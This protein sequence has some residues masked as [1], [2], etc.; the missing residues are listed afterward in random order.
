MS[1]E[2]NSGEE[3]DEAL[4][5]LICEYLHALEAGRQPDRAE[6][7]AAHPGLADDLAEF[8]A[9]HDQFGGIA[10]PLRQATRTTATGGPPYGAPN[11]TNGK[12]VLA[13]PPS[14]PDHA[15]HLAGVVEELGRLGDFQMVREVGRGGMG[16]V[17]EAVQISLKR[18]VALKVLP[19]AGALDP[20]QLQRFK[21]E[22]QAAAHLTHQHIVPVYFVGCERG[23]HFYAMQ[24]IDGQT[25]AQVIAE[26]RQL[27]APG[28]DNRLP[29]NGPT[30]AAEAVAPGRNPSPA[31]ADEERTSPYRP[32]LLP[33][34]SAAQETVPQAA[35][36]TEGSHRTAAYF[37]TVARLGEQAAE[38]LHHAHEMGVVHRDVK[39]G[40]LLLDGRANVWVTDFGLARMQT[41]ASLTLS[42]DLVGTLRY[43]SPEQ[44]LANRVAIDH[45]T[46]VYSLGATLYELLVLRPTFA[47]RERQELLRQIAFD[48]PAPLRRLNKAIP[49]ELETVVLKALEK[50]P[51]DRYATAKELAADLRR[52]LEDRPI[53][54]HRP[55]LA[56]RMRK[57]GRR[58]RLVVTAAAICLLVTLAAVVGSVGWVLGERA[59][60][61]RGA[62][63]KVRE[64]LDA[65]APGLRHGNPYDPGLIAAVQR[66]EAQL[67]TG[68]VG[69]GLGALVEQLRRDREMLVQLE[70]AHSQGLAGNKET[71]FNYAGQDQL[72]MQAFEGH[73][74]K[75]TTLDPQEAARRLRT[76]AIRTH[77]IAALEEWAQAKS[78]LRRRRGE[79]LIALADLADDDPWRRRLRRV[80]R[81]AD[82]IE[83]QRLARENAVLSQPAAN[84]TLLA[85]AL[86]NAGAWAVAE[87]V[88]RLAQ[89]AHPSEL[90]LNLDLAAMLRQK[91]RPDPA[92]AIRFQQAALALRPDK[93][94]LYMDLGI[95][96]HTEGKLTEAVAAHRKATELNSDYAAA[97]YNLGTALADQGKFA[98]A[99]GAFRKAVKLKPD[100]ALVHANLG[101]AL[102][103]Q[104]RL[105][106][107]VAAYRK[108]ISLK[109][110]D[111]ISHNNLGAALHQ[112]GNLIEA[113]AEY[114]KA[115]ALKPN[116]CDAYSN[117]GKALR[118]QHNLENAVLAFRKAI[119]LKPNLP[120]LHHELGNLLHS[121]HKLVEAEAAFGMAIRLKANYYD[122]Y[123]HLGMVLAEQGKVDLAE[124]AFR[125]AICLKPD[126]VSAHFN[127]GNE[128]SS[129]GKVREAIAEYKQAVRLK[130]SF[131][132][133]YSNLGNAFVRNGQLNEAITAFQQ[134]SRLKD[135][136]RIHWNLG[137]ALWKKDRL[138]EAAAQFRDVIR[139]NKDHA[140]AHCYLGVAL[141]RMG[142]PDEAIAELRKAIRLK[143]DFAEP[144]YIL[145]NALSH[146]KGQLDNA[147][148]EYREAIRLK[149][150]YADAHFNLGNALAAKGQ[151]ANAIGQYRHAIRLKPAFGEAHC[152]LGQALR[153]RLEY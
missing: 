38:A 89:Q 115:I 90:W 108:A 111:S 123:D 138:E 133:A 25:L 22:S 27:A 59:A 65:A 139:L 101:N 92:E 63:A 64:A 58:H 137:V 66:A 10:A 16:I 73:G 47:G 105:A 39:P 31:A 21:N 136:A 96:L 36:T 151:L 118:D 52:W 20:K 152:N 48:E 132:E 149:K 24:Y 18:R 146:K 128:L 150:E 153:G 116:Y 41:E 113:E 13:D 104:G 97:H 75:V 98:L 127:L 107:A 70:Q 94:G 34:G 32:H 93:A 102:Y 14:G 86:R 53:Q 79:C 43:M 17:Y 46:D 148:G 126:N 74:L 35:L 103:S 143:N 87:R 8:F 26:L 37:R 55:T 62:E 99:E 72:Y 15:A 76:S 28:E 9:A 67:G 122:S 30:P 4:S 129:Q 110:N 19:F 78:N 12:A 82:K 120:E 144:H 112:Q 95:L 106:E 2:S 147:I 145:G 124:A 77:L 61:R 1:H 5:G 49:A 60:Q 121:Q 68:V 131:P 100:F 40:N 134:G 117:L 130:K 71:P 29:V 50:R 69:P 141:E 23:V 109:S 91:K 88:L 114:H 33:P 57:W 83:L 125:K 80:M 44:A 140:E 119:Q 7:L 135:D 142:Q 3:H 54:A 81:R 6:L 84:V 85:R 51:E 56:Q 45:R 11:D 42:G